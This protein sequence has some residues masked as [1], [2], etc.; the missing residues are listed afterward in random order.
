M[1][2]NMRKPKCR[3]Y[4]YI[5]KERVNPDILSNVAAL[6]IHGGPDAQTSISGENWSL[7]SNR[8]AIIDFEGGH[9]PYALGDHIKVVFNG[10]IYNHRELKECLT[11]RG[12][13]FPNRCD[14]AIL[15]ALYAEYGSDFV[16]YL[17]GMFAIALVDLKKPSTLVLAT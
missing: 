11:K 10:E 3:I 8:L 13:Q 14:G 7:G 5:S 1:S 2:R 6:Q 12:Y 15:P 9:Q 17:D 16:R 4:G